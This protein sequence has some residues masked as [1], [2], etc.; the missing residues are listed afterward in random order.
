MA[1]GMPTIAKLTCTECHAER[2]LALPFYELRMVLVLHDE[3]TSPRETDER[4]W[5]CSQACV[6]RAVNRAIDKVAKR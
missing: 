2:D 6:V 1:D 3:R 5:L 4:E